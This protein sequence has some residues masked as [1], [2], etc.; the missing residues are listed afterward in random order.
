ITRAPQKLKPPAGGFCIQLITQKLSRDWLRFSV[1][2]FR[3]CSR[4]SWSGGL[5]GWLHTLHHGVASSSAHHHR[6]R[7]RGNHKD[8]GRP[9]RCLCENVSRRSW[10]KS[11]LRTHAAKS[12]CDVGA[13]AALKEHNDDHED[14]NYNVDGYNEIDHFFLNNAF[15]SAIAGP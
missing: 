3:R 2:S 10:T 13:L 14:A 4:L 5:L 6:E 9:S 15:M 7:D 11:C 1:R 8:Y 12:R